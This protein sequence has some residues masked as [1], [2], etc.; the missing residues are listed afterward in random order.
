[1]FKK[2]I[3]IYAVT[4]FNDE[5]VYEHLKKT[6]GIFG[7][8]GWTHHGRDAWAFFE[9]KTDYSYVFIVTCRCSKRKAEKIRR[10]GQILGEL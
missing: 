9:D 7:V 2:K 6:Q 8:L 1:M 3:R 5:I 10:I 4:K